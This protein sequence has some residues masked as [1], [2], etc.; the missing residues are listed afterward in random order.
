MKYKFLSC[1]I[2]LPFY[3]VQLPPPP[4]FSP[5]F[6][7]NLRN[8][9]SGKRNQKTGIPEKTGKVTCLPINKYDDKCFHYT[10]TVALNHKEIE[11]SS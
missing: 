2:L 9:Y 8:E 7:V 11:H 6:H 3:P 5:R 4:R 1:L 10:A